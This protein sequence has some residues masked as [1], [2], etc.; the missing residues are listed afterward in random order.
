[1]PVHVESAPR[2]WRRASLAAVGALLVAVAGCGEDADEGV[3]APGTPLIPTSTTAITTNQPELD[4]GALRTAG[5][6]ALAAVQDSTLI[7]IE[8]ERDRGWEVQVVTGDGVEHELEVSGDGNTVVLG[9]T[10]KNEDESDRAEHRDRIGAARVDYQAAADT[11][12]EEV[13]GGT[14]T[15][16]NLDGDNGTTVWE[17]DVID[18]SRVKHEVTIDAES[19]EV[20]ASRSER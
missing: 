15:E 3:A 13:P 7:S 14:I 5:R 6:T 1:M 17:A 8:T 4:L 9:P 20:V 16:L 18:S 12:L 10:A 11:V 19:G 2:R